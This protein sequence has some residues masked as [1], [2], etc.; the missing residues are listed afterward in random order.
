[1][2]NKV[3]RLTFGTAGLMCIWSLEAVNYLVH[4]VMRPH[5]WNTASST[6]GYV[7]WSLQLACFVRCQFIL[8][9]FASL[10]WEQQALAGEVPSTVCKR[11]GRLLPERAVYVRRADAVVLG[12]DHY[13][14]W[15]GSPI[16]FRNRKFFVLFV[17][18]SALF[19]AMGVAHSAYDLLC[20]LPDTLLLPPAHPP[21]LPAHCR[22]VSFPDALRDALSR[23][24]LSATAAAFVGACHRGFGVY[25]RSLGRAHDANQLAYALLLTL[26]VP[27]NLLAALLLAWLSIEQVQLAARNRTTLEPTDGR[28]DMGLA[29]NLRQIFGANALYWWLPTRAELPDGN[30]YSWP[31]NPSYRV[32]TRRS[33]NRRAHGRA[34]AGF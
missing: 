1:M 25:L 16:G 24:H 4:V 8:P 34:A 22:H 5:Q 19:C 31:L 21:S 30:G 9:G 7:V 11:S 3:A 17:C 6:C 15:L 20:T 18:Y 23:H 13:C 26:T 14:I 2:L 33:C 27:A 29:A 10:A 28:Y 12:L 32:R